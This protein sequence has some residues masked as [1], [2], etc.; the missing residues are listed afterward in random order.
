LQI[1]QAEKM[2]S[3]YPDTA[4][5]ISSVTLTLSGMEFLEKNGSFL[6]HSRHPK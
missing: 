6:L 2:L 3:K 1:N 4:A 5:F